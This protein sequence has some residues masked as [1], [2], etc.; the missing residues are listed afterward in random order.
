M[1]DS[2]RSICVPHFFPEE[3]A[4]SELDQRAGLDGW[5]GYF[6]GKRLAL[7]GWG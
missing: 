4:F 5:G 2:E 6:P 3:Y 1:D 7:D